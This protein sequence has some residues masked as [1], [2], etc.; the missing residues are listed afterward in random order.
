MRDLTEYIDRFC[1]NEYGHTNWAFADTLT[2]D[3]LKDSNIAENDGEIVF[4]KTDI[5]E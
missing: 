1:E 4:Y 2:K 3:E 5:E